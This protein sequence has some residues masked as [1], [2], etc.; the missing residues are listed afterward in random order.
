M[1]NELFS[2]PKNHFL[3]FL[4]IDFKI[5]LFILIF[6]NIMIWYGLCISYF[7]QTPSIFHNISKYSI[8]YHW[9]CICF[10]SRL[11]NNAR[12]IMVYKQQNIQ[13]TEWEIT[14]VWC[15]NVFILFYQM[16]FFLI[17]CFDSFKSNSLWLILKL[18]T[19]LFVF[20]QFSCRVNLKW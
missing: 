5:N 6:L 2:W 11:F 17:A 7:S 16:F 4:G 1:K 20:W 3:L 18:C 19:S 15:L 12:N 8:A 10:Y 13:L 9:F 14:Y